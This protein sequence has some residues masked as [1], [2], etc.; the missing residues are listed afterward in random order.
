MLTREE[1][2]R[3]IEE[4][5]EKIKSFG[6]KKLVLFGSYARNE[7]REDSDIDFLVEFEKGRGLFDDFVHLLHFLEKI[8]GRK[9]DLGEKHLLR[10]ELK[11]NILEGEKV[12]TKI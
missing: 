5:K 8:L 9:V 1:I 10:E 6:V 12:E 2:I 3:K 7:G 11:S 4:N